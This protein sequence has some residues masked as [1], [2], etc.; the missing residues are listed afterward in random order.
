M[1][2]FRHLLENTRSLIARRRMEGN[3]ELCGLLDIVD[4]RHVNRLVTISIRS[5][6]KAELLAVQI[7]NAYVR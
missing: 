3:D 7:P 2:R 6:R 4:S 5:L 1:T